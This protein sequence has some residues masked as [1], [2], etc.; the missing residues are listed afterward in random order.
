MKEKGD[1]KVMPRFLDKQL[2]GWLY[3]LLIQEIIGEEFVG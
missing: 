1:V 2:G 3:H